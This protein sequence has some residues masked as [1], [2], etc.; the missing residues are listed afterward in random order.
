MVRALFEVIATV[1]RWLRQQFTRYESNQ[2]VFWN[3]IMVVLGII[4]LKQEGID[5]TLGNLERYTPIP[6]SSIYRTLLTLD[7]YGIIKRVDDDEHYDFT[8]IPADILNISTRRTPQVEIDLDG[9]ISEIKS[10][11]KTSVRDALAGM[12]IKESDIEKVTKRIDEIKPEKK[13]LSPLE[14]LVGEG[15]Q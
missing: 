1:E 7:S 2:R 8:D 12:S 4:M 11:V 9:V 15:F 10:M 13:K 5:V 14:M 3:H 6:K